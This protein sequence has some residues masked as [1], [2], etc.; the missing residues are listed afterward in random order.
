MVMGDALRYRV[1]PLAMA[2]LLSALGCNEATISLFSVQKAGAAGGAGGAGNAGNA[3][4]AGSAGAPDDP[5]LISHWPFDGDANERLSGTAATLEGDLTFVDDPVRGQVLSCDG[6]TGVLSFKNETPLDFSYAFW[7]WVAQPLPQGTSS[8]ARSPVVWS[9][10]EGEV[11]D[12]AIWLRG[13]RVFYL[14]Y[15]KTATGDT[16]L[17]ESTWYHIVVT[18]KDGEKVT[19]YLDGRLEGD[20]NASMGP[21]RANPQ[22]FVCG[23]P[24]DTQHLAGRIDDL[25]LYDKPLTA[26][27]VQ[28]LYALTLR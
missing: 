17:T 15:S 1:A 6:A 3:G 18:R 28:A 20:G 19:L 26:E 24:N 5:D 25:R 22:V 2:A 10:V 8:L 4:S 23:N 16:I 13:S 7:L 21:V 11:D 12:F 9:N 27:E 14:S